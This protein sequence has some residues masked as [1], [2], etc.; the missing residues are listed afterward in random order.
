[1]SG[2]RHPIWEVAD[3]LQMDLRA[4]NA[5]LVELRARLAAMDLPDHVEHRCDCG[6]SFRSRRELEEHLYT[7]HDGPLPESYRRADELAGERAA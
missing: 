3:S 2:E 6:S 4:A 5:K 1:M 7:A